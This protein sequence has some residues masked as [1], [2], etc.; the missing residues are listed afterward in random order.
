M[1]EFSKSE[2]NYCEIILSSKISERTSNMFKNLGKNLIRE[3]QYCKAVFAFT[4]SA[5]DMFDVIINGGDEPTDYSRNTYI[6]EQKCNSLKKT[7]VDLYNVDSNQVIL[8]PECNKMPETNPGRYNYKRAE[9]TKYY[10]F[11]VDDLHCNKPHTICGEHLDAF[12]FSISSG[13]L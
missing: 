2:S 4:K 12:S 6:L 11:V 10:D 8:P 13:E 7:I 9:L 1:S 3:G 5:F